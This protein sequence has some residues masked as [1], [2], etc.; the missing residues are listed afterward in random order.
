MK[1][2]LAWA[3]ERLAFDHIADKEGDGT[4][5]RWLPDY[6]NEAALGWLAHFAEQI[7]RDAIRAAADRVSNVS[8][9]YR[10]VEAENAL[11]RETNLTVAQVL[12]RESGHLL[13]LLPEE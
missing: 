3:E 1:S 10:E 9:M 12:F 13:S 11:Q 5:L 7:Q 4:P 6:A 2:A 8:A